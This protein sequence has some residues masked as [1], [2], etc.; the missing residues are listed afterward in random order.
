MHR[1]LW[2]GFLLLLLAPMAHGQS[3]IK[4]GK[5]STTFFYTQLN[6]NAGIST[7]PGGTQFGIPNYG[8]ANQLAFQLM[9]KSQSNLQRGYVPLI[10]LSSWRIRTSL[11]YSESVD[12]DGDKTGFR[13]INLLDAWLKFGTKWDRTSF[14]VG[15]GQMTYGHNPALDPVSNFMTN[16]MSADLGFSR[17]LGVYLKTPVSRALDLEVGLTSGGWMGNTLL[18]TTYEFGQDPVVVVVPN[19]GP[20]GG[21]GGG[22]GGGGGPGGGGGNG[23]GG[24]NVVVVEEGTET[25]SS[26]SFRDLSY[27]GTW[28]M[29]GRLGQQSFRSSEVGLIGAA[30]RINSHFLDGETMGV[31]HIGLDWVYKKQ[32]RFRLTNQFATGINSASESGSFFSFS[33]QNN[34]DVFLHGK[35]ILSF[36]HSLNLQQG[37]DVDVNYL[38]STLSN[39]LTYVISPHTRLRLNQRIT[40]SDYS[41]NSGYGVYLQFVTGLGKR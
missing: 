19:E 25:T 41:G 8:P 12:A 39:S 9:G 38:A 1:S 6:L 5:Q 4:L 15:Y 2:A 26:T 37:R 10:S 29:S 7:G 16:M 13:S 33:L 23:N 40:A 31:A 20:G 27:N 28:L 11:S 30:G 24:G 34:L 36:A 35:V 3:A 21:N 17:D 32:E 22:N 18:S 14:K